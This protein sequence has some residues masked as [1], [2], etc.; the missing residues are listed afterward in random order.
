MCYFLFFIVIKMFALM[1]SDMIFSVQKGKQPIKIV[2]WSPWSQEVT[3]HF[4]V[5][6]GTYELPVPFSKFFLMCPLNEAV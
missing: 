5:A 4:T 1:L 6:Q 3:S 2:P